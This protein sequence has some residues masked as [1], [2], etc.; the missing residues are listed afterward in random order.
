MK[1]C[2]KHTATNKDG[3]KATCHIT[4]RMLGPS[5][6]SQQF[7]SKGQVSCLCPTPTR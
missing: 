3:I 5:N 7:H 1:I 2:K 6:K 4:C